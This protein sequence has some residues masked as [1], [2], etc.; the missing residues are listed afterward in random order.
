MQLAVNINGWLKDN[1]KVI[2]FAAAYLG[3]WFLTLTAYLP[4]YSLTFALAFFAFPFTIIKKYTSTIRWPFVFLSVLFVSLS[5]IVPV[6]TVLFFSIGFAVFVL[7]GDYVGRAGFLSCC[8]LV[9]VAPVFQYAVN[10]FSFPIRLKITAFAG[11]LFSLSSNDVFIK[12]NVILYNGNEFSVDPACMGLNMLVTSLLL[13]VMLIGFYQRK[14]GRELRWF[15]VLVC[16]AVIVS[17][18]IFSNLLRIVLLVHFAILP[19]DDLHE[20]VGLICLGV[21]VLLPSAFFVR[22]LVNR[23]ARE[24]KQSLNQQKQF[25]NGAFLHLLLLSAIGFSAYNISKSD[26]YIDYHLK[27]GTIADYNASK[28]IPG[29]IKLE[30]EKALAYVKYIRGFYDSDHNPTICWKGSGYEFENTRIEEVCSFKIYRASLVSGNDKLY[31]A[32]WYSNGDDDNTADPLQWRWR[33]MQNKKR[34]AVINVTAATE[35]E[36]NAELHR[37]LTQKL[38]L[39]L[40]VKA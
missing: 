38:L 35:K 17:L 30:S 28:F 37:I 26:T 27:T 20:I 39:P 9:F 1:K 31:T 34:Y 7:I 11:N 15:F 29:V 16:F 36:L 10:V 33:M 18:N 14:Y 8:T 32:W 22:L 4:F 13:G 19:Q 24:Q 40:F 12:G 2:A 6:K 3:I 21:Y 5:F 23:L 25:K